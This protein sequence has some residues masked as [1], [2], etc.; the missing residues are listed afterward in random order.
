MSREGRVNKPYPSWLAY[1][2]T[3]LLRCHISPQ[4]GWSPAGTLRAVRSK[5]ADSSE[6]CNPLQ[7]DDGAAVVYR[8]AGQWT[9]KEKATL[10]K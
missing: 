7:S 9:E 1:W 5:T 2:L 3:S 4:E 8:A 6:R 10:L